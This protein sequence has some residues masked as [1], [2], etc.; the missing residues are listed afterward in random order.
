[1]SMQQNLFLLANHDRL[2][3]KQEKRNTLVQ[4]MPQWHMLDSNKASGEMKVKSFKRQKVRK[5][6]QAEKGA[7]IKL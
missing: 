6:V 1:M 5:S 7:K 4:G 2:L 3:K